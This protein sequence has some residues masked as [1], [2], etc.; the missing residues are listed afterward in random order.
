MQFDLLEKKLCYMHRARHILRVV[1]MD[2]KKNVR[3]LCVDLLQWCERRGTQNVMTHCWVSNCLH[4]ENS[5]HKLEL[6]AMFYERCATN[7][8]IQINIVENT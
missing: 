2:N 1:N 3:S 6:G 4:H 8:V 7:F 5:Q